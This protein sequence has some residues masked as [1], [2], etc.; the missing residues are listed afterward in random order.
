[1]C[2]H[3]SDNANFSDFESIANRFIIRYLGVCNGIHGPSADKRETLMAAT[4]K[5]TEFDVINVCQDRR[6]I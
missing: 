5:V 1:M 4:A 6:D 3:L 2:G